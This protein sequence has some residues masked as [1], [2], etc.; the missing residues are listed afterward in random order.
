MKRAIKAPQYFSLKCSKMTNAVCNLLQT[1]FLV[2]HILTRLIPVIRRI[3]IEILLRRKPF[4]LSS[5][6]ETPLS[7]N[8]HRDLFFRKSGEKIVFDLSQYEAELF[9]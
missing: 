8:A 4:G 9:E 5:R 7:R 1:A 6:S 2:F 3:I